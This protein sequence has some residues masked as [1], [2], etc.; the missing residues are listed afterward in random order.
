MKRRFRI[1]ILG[2][3]YGGL[4]AAHSLQSLVSKR[5]A[6]IVLID[7]NTYHANKIDL[8][9]VAMGN[10]LAQDISYDIIPIVRKPHVRVVKGEVLSIF[11]EARIVQTDSEKFSYDFLVIALGFVPETFGI[12]GLD[13]HAFQISNLEECEAISMHMEDRFREFAFTEHIDRAAGDIRILV[14]GSGFT[15]IE[16]LGDLVERL[17]RLCKKYGI[18]RKSVKVDCVSADERLLPMLCDSAVAQTKRYLE[19]SG[20]EF[21]MGAR[22]IRATPNSFVYIDADGIEREIVAHTRIWTGGVSGSPLMEKTFGD[23]VRRGRLKVRQDLA[24]DGFPE[25]Y[26]IGD[27]SAFIPAGEE[28]PLPTTAQAAT[29]M[30]HHAAVNIAKQVLKRPRVPFVYKYK[31]TVCSLGSI[32]GVADL[33]GRVLYGF[34]AMRLKRFIESYTDYRISGL[35]NAV[36]YNRLFKFLHP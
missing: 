10:A 19:R 14:G 16:L 8:H 15:G 29:Q 21:H 3:G 5:K 4:C 17:P 2:A 33:H 23:A 27:C 34:W 9:E 22:I 20:V 11:P 18:D 32:N 24:V 13:E 25:I 1:V 28:R 26:V 7:R 12:P 35:R 31:G 36:K 30:G 6:E